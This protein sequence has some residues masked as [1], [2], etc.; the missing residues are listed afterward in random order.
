MSRSMIVALAGSAGAGKSTAAAYLEARYGFARVR[1]AGPLKAMVRAFLS[2]AGTPATEI[3]RMVEGDRK[4]VSASELAG[5][6]PRHVMQTLGTEWGRDLI[7]PDLWT[8]AWAAGARAA[9][10][11]GAPGVVV[12]DCR[13][14]NEVDAVRAL[15]GRVVRIIRP[16]GA[17]TLDFHPSEGQSLAVDATI[18][19]VG[20]L[21]DLHALLDLVAQRDAPAVARQI[22][23]P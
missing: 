12:E 7:H 21:C 14:P 13:F 19:N 22:P 4:Q 9:L 16:V 23:A 10:D 2:E 8:M 15:G 6:S 18:A 17:L 11:R 20:P 1:F 3:E 5:R